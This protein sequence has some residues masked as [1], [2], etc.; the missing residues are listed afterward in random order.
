MID[1]HA[2]LYAEEFTKDIDLVIDRA[3]KQG[4]EKI[5]LPNVNLDTLEPM[6]ALEK[7]YPYVLSSMLGLHPCDVKEDYL[8]VLRVMGSK[9]SQHDFVGIGEIG[10]DLYWD[11]TFLNEQIDA[12]K[13]QLN[14]AKKA[15]LPVSIHIRDAFKETFDVLANEQDGNLKGVIHCFTGNLEQAKYL[16]EELGFYLGFGGVTTFKSSLLGSFLPKIDKSKIILE[17]DSPY[18]SPVPKRG[19]RNEPA[20]TYYTANFIA[21]CLS[22]SLAEL[23]DL[24]TKNTKEL[25]K[26]S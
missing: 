19:Q 21:S 23:D 7:K 3:L 2:H 17:T 18:L 11:K 14:W 25:F 16:T 26:L 5:I 8:H 4:I 10:I 6:L 24:T 13:I 12:L 22:M 1:T 15:D 20:N 9:L